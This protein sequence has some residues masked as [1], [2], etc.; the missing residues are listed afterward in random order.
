[1]STDTPDNAHLLL[2]PMSTV[3]LPTVLEIERQVQLTPWTEGHFLDSFAACHHLD[4]AVDPVG[5]AGYA[6]SHC[7]VDEAHVLTIAVAPRAQRTGV[8]TFLFAALTTAMAAA[9]ACR[10]FLEVRESNRAARAFYLRHGLIDIGRRKGYYALPGDVKQRE[11][12]LVM[13]CDVPGCVDG[14]AA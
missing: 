14:M 7:V 3:D 13:A 11:D 12:A 2:R 9:G 8:G 1:M 4:V 6:V 5:V 10:L